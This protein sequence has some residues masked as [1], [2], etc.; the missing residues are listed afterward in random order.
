MNIDLQFL[1][2]DFTIRGVHPRFR[3]TVVA[4]WIVIGLGLY[5]AIPVMAIWVLN[6]LFPVLAIH[7]GFFEWCAMLILLC[8]VWLLNKRGE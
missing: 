3:S 1:G 5:A 7:Y 6:T 8:A 2:Y 4:C